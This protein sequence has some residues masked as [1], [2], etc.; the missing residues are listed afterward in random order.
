MFLNVIFLVVL[1]DVVFSQNSS[2]Y[3]VGYYQNGLKQFSCYVKIN[4]LHSITCV[5]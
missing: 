5:A 2:K 4:Y 1:F 3:C